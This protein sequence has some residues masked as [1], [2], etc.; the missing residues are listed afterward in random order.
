M[1]TAAPLLHWYA[2]AEDRIPPGTAWLHR[3]EQRRLSRYRFTKRRTEYCL[4]RVAGK[5]AVAAAL[6]L[7][8]T[9]PQDLGRIGVLTAPG[10]APYVVL[11]DEPCALEVSLTDRA[12]HAVCLVGPEGS[13]RSVGGLGVDVEIVEERS[14]DFVRDF[15]TGREQ[16]WLTGQLVGSPDAYAAGANLVWSAKEAALKVQRVGLRADTRTVDVSVLRGHR[17]DGWS[18]LTVDH[19]A[20]AYPG[21]WRRDGRF[22]LTVVTRYPCDPPQPLPG[23]LDLATATPVHSWI[24]AP[25]RSP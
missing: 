13:S 21:W 2:C 10:G 3:S 18:R 6:G 14:Q 17:S 12:G 16:R 7:D 8:I 25:L 22:L 11:D 24:A 9:T 4:R 19:R 15:L 23:S 5:Y 20:G 1:T